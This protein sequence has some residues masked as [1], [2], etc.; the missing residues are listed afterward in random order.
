MG[1]GASGTRESEGCAGDIRI[2]LVGALETTDPLG[3]M[4]LVVMTVA[5]QAV[6]VWTKRDA[7]FVIAALETGQGLVIPFGMS[8]TNGAQG[9]QINM[10]IFEDLIKTFAR[11]AEHFANA[12]VRKTL[13]QMLDPWNGQQ[14]IVAVSRG[15]GTG[16]GPDQEET[17]VNDVEGFGFVPKVMFAVRTGAGLPFGLA[18][19]VGSGLVGARVIDI[20]CLR[21][22]PGGEATVLVTG[23][24]IAGTAFPTRFSCWTSSLSGRLGTSRYLVAALHVRTRSDQLA[25]SGKGNA[26]FGRIARKSAVGGNELAVHQGLHQTILT[27]GEPIQMGVCESHAE[28][29]SHWQVLR[30]KAQATAIFLT[31]C[32]RT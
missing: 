4:T 31:A 24:G 30:I 28:G 27:G 20:G 11:I 6:A 12:E 29:G 23:G 3:G 13:A 16:Q 15:A 21:I 19:L 1:E 9:V 10:H 25:I 26:L 8:Q 7:V 5:G 17:I 32:G 18:W 22:A 2:G 14:V